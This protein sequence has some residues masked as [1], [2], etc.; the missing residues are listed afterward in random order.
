MISVVL[1]T[2]SLIVSIPK[3]SEFRPIFD[4]LIEGEFKLLISTEILNEYAEKLE[5][6]MSAVVAFNVVE[7]ITQMNH[8]EKTEIY[9]RWHLINRD[10]DDNKFVDCAIA[11][12]AQFIVTDDKHYRILKDIPFPS[13]K[14]IKTEAF[15]DMIVNG[16]L[17]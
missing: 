9:Y 10:V 7:M 16:E 6:K 3:R 5:E 13:V 12:N 4:A 2:N 14:V 11:G 8:A 1:D 15:R 17:S